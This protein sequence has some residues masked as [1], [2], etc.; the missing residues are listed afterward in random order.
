MILVNW[1]VANLPI[2]AEKL[3]MK[4]YSNGSYLIRQKQIQGLPNEAIL[5]KM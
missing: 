5:L 4:W 3:D 2:F 1:W